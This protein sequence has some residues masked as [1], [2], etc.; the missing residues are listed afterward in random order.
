MQSE[1]MPLLLVFLYI[2]LVLG[3]A[4]VGY[5]LAVR[6]IRGRR[7]GNEPHCPRCNYL[8]VG[9]SSQHCPECGAALAPETIV[10]GQRVVDRKRLGFASVLLLA[11]ASVG[12]FLLL[13]A[14][15]R[16]EW[17]HYEPS[18]WVMQE[19]ANPAFQGRA[20]AEMNRRD[21]RSPISNGHRN[22]MIERA[23]IEQA[24]PTVGRNTK[25][26][27]EFLGRQWRSGRLTSAQEK[28]FFENAGQ[29]SLGVGKEVSP[30]RAVGRNG[31]AAQPELMFLFNQ[32]TRLP[33]GF[34]VSFTPVDVLIDGQASSI[35]RSFRPRQ[36]AK[37]QS[38]PLIVSG[39]EV[40]RTP[41]NHTLEVTYRFEVYDGALVPTNRTGR[42]FETGN[43]TLLFSED[44]SHS[45]TFTVK[46]EDIGRAQDNRVLPL[47][48]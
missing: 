42:P 29:S 44:R 1:H 32:S 21:L 5:F 30:T 34:W 23:L 13:P 38:Q 33:D 24:A 47:S 11:T 35:V 45:T 37:L 7:V 4:V 28:R 20:L 12:V 27:L 16:V 26:L 18:S 15:E 6:G 41:G 22:I 31:L 36:L 10:H 43:S 2:A 19:F 40:L 48:R 17:Y 25:S 3:G 8:V 14:V 9:I 39:L 46:P